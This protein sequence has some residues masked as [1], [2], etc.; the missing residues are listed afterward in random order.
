MGCWNSH[1]SFSEQEENGDVALCVQL[2]S[3][4]VK[5][6]GCSILKRLEPGAKRSCGSFGQ[7]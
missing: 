4:V 5:E 6:E 2:W 1:L 3:T 7:D